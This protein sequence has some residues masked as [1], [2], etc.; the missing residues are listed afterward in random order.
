MPGAFMGLIGS[1]A[2][3]ETENGEIIPVRE[4]RRRKNPEGRCRCIERKVNAANGG[5]LQGFRWTA[6]LTPTPTSGSAR[7]T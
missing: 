6:G 2:A 7:F 4:K 5:P 3:P 1:D